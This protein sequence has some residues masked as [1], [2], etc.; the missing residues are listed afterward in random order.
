[1]KKANFSTLLVIAI[2]FCGLSTFLF[3]CYSA[4]PTLLSSDDIKVLQVK[5]KNDPDFKLEN[6]FDSVESFSFYL[7]KGSSK[8][9]LDT[10]RKKYSTG[11][12]P[13]ICFMDPDINDKNYSNGLS[14]L[15]PGEMYGVTLYKCKTNDALSENVI[16]F[17]E[18]RN[19]IFVGP[20][21]L[22]LIWEHRWRLSKEDLPRGGLWIFSFDKKENLLRSAD[23]NLQIPVIGSDLGDGCSFL[24]SSFNIK[25]SKSNYFICIN[26]ID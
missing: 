21:V 20:Q 13:P 16:K 1:M 23:G 14:A 25:L 18:K 12:N 24:L 5:Q 19:A 9:I 10:L 22:A 7:Q 6:L 2:L 4:G 8:Y 3:S 17:L 15:V 26:E 11:F